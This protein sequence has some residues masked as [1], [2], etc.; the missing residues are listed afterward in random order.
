M[1]GMI[2][3]AGP[4]GGPALSALHACRPPFEAARATVSP[5]AFHVL[6]CAIPFRSY[7]FRTPFLEPYGGD[8]VGP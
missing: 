8:I 7:G 5:A 4:H 1:I 6:R 2:R 3:S